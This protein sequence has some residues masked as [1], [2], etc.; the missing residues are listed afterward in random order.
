[1]GSIL[2]PIVYLA[3]QYLRQ[4]RVDF[5]GHDLGICGTVFY[6]PVLASIAESTPN[7]LS[8]PIARMPNLSGGEETDL[9]AAA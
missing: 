6:V 3:M 9:F 7:R 2:T 4:T 8:Y 5:S 1:M